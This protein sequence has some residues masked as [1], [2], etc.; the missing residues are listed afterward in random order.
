MASSRLLSFP[1]E[2]AVIMFLHRTSVWVVNCGP[3]QSRTRIDAS[4]SP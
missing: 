4:V 1:V 3:Q 2:Y